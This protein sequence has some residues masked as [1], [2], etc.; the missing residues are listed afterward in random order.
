MKIIQIFKLI[1]LLEKIANSIKKKI[2]NL[3]LVSNDEIQELNKEH[4]NI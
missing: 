3:M 1:L 2:L 4:R